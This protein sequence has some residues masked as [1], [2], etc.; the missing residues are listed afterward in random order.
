MLS[1]NS[2]NEKVKELLLEIPIGRVTTYGIIAEKCG[3]KSSARM[4]GYI[5]NSLK[6][7]TKYPCHR[8]VNRFG[9]LSGK[10]HF[11]G[12][13]LMQEL[14]ESEG[15]EVTDNKVK[16]SNYLWNPLD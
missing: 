1:E 10:N 13:E 4:V 14:L 11:Q 9:E 5:L 2:F 6:N 7:Q 12:E 3:M 16:L 15:I 8:V